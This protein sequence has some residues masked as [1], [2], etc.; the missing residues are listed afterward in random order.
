MDWKWKRRK[1]PVALS[2]LILALLTETAGCTKPEGGTAKLDA[3]EI[4]ASSKDAA[5]QSE[6]D[7]ADQNDQDALAA[8]G[9]Y[10]ETQIQT[11]QDFSGPCCMQRLSDKSLVLLDLSKFQVSI[12]M[13]DG[14]S[15]ETKPA[16][17]L[18]KLWMKESMIELSSAAISVDGEVFLACNSLETDASGVTY[19]KYIS[20]S[21]QEPE[22]TMRIFTLNTQEKAEYLCES[23]FTPDGRLFALS[24]VGQVYEIFPQKESCRQIFTVEGAAAGICANEEFLVAAVDNQVYFYDLKSKE[25]EADDEVLNA[26][27]AGQTDKTAGLALCMGKDGTDGRML[28]LA[29]CSGLVGHIKDG[30]VMEEL[31]DA[32]LASLG[33]P[34]KRPEDILQNEDGS[35]FVLFQDGELYAYTYD[36]EAPA[37]P[38]E[39]LVIYGL[40]D[41]ETIRQAIS[42]FRKKY[43]EVFVRF[44]TGLSGEDGMTKTDAVKNLNTRLLAGEGPDLI[45]LD[46]L[47]L[48]AYEEKGILEDLSG[49]AD[50]LTQTGDY[51]E[52]ILNGFQNAAGVCALPFRY[53]VPL[54]EGEGSILEG[55]T[56]LST[57]ADT[58]E[59]L[60]KLSTTPETVLGSYWAEETLEK[61][62]LTSANAWLDEQGKVDQEA[63]R[64]F[65][66]QAKRIYEA[67]Q[68]NLDAQELEA[69]R[70]YTDFI[71]RH[72]EKESR[73]AQKVLLGM[74]RAIQQI[75]E[76]QLITVGYVSSMHD[77]L[78][79]TALQREL[80]KKGRSLEYQIWNGQEGMQFIPTGTIGIRTHTAH[81]ER[82][83]AFIRVLL[84][85]DVQGRDFEDGFPV[86][87]SAYEAFTTDPQP[88]KVLVTGE[89]DR[90]GS[91]VVLG[92]QWP[93]EQELEQLRKVLESLQTPAVF[94]ENLKNEVIT[95]GAQVLRGEKKVEEGAR[96]IAQ[97]ISLYLN[98]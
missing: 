26:Y 32:A 13:D 11:P 42:T 18:E 6:G 70:E 37:V 98:E 91:Q 93:K 7:G 1:Y 38:E 50:E 17:G 33:D 16:A 15:W 71:Q 40:Y 20:F 80:G 62:Y 19:G 61:L 97:K 55:I 68:K 73:E 57:L 22:Q 41:N 39:Q 59:E 81:R 83:E 94:E 8:K 2:A 45:L 92:L 30:S 79:M 76:N 43:P 78:I 58:A 49:L 54:I 24:T 10:V 90:A 46:E 75:P 65:L 89:E 84:G 74:G 25:L 60:S 36:K 23:V 29:G 52:G 87:A 96:E 66:E 48:H 14:K 88:E 9:R 44:E 4:S 27:L 86:N 3:G 35:F 53:Q 64:D 34:S 31:V 95:I 12:S 67:D 72:Y 47:P 63:L 85:S 77:F 21:L 5:G 82:A 51:F 69:H 28:Y 56:D